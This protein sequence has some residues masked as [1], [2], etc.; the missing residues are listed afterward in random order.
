MRKGAA[1]AGAAAGARAKPATSEYAR[2]ASGKAKAA[3]QRCLRSTCEFAG[4]IDTNTKTAAAFVEALSK[5]AYR[6]MRKAGEFEIPGIGTLVMKRT[7]PRTGRNA[8]TGPQIKIHHKR[9]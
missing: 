5:I 2:Q 8:A 3:R 7:L 9:S 4:A 6:E 1:T